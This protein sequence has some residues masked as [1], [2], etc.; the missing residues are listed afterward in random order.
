MAF[1]DWDVING[2][3]VA[4]LEGGDDGLQ[5]L[6]TGLSSPLVSQGNDARQ[7]NV[8][9]TGTENE[10]K[11]NLYLVKSTSEATLSSIPNTKAA[12]AEIWVRVKNEDLTTCATT[13]DGPEQFGVTIRG[14][15]ISTTG[16]SPDGISLLIGKGE[17]TNVT[18]GSIMAGSW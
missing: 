4:S 1:A 3:A 15:G 18:P 10:K 16:A 9:L 12:R 17:M 6:H 7:W 13:Y 14:G 5:Q 8:V 2:Y 11:S